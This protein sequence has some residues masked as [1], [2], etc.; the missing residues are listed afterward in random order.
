MKKGRKSMKA[1]GIFEAKLT[2]LDAAD[3]R[4]IK[5]RLVKELGRNLLHNDLVE[6]DIE[7]EDNSVRIVARINVEKLSESINIKKEESI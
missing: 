5:D 7:Y 4:E 2:V 6:F 1:K 3:I